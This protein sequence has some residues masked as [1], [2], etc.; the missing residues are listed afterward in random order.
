MTSE[1]ASVVE[2]HVLTLEEIAKLAEETGQPAETLANLVELNRPA[3]QD[4]RLLGL[5][6][7]ARSRQPGV[8]GDRRAAETSRGH[9]CAL[10][11]RKGWR[12]WSRNS[13]AGGGRT[14]QEASAL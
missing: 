1:T 14:S 13:S 11:Y 5:F 12:G 4:G 7:G 3:I 10:S 6:T 2:A 8:G 9:I